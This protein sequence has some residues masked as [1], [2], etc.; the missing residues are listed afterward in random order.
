MPLREGKKVLS[1]PD[2][3]KGG[4]CIHPEVFVEFGAGWGTNPATEQ[5]GAEK[6]W[7]LTCRTLCGGIISEIASLF[8]QPKV[9][10][11]M[12]TPA[13]LAI[14]HSVTR[15]QG[16]GGHNLRKVQFFNVLD[17]GDLR[18]NQPRPAQLS[19]ASVWS[20][21]EWA[22][23]FCCDN[24]HTLGGCRQQTPILLRF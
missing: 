20:A 17:S 4:Y 5:T 21:F 14:T 7:P 16:R 22:F 15:P 6:W 3:A 18:L 10:N 19:P 12:W 24:S 23:S 11:S 13:T 1:F 9:S 2:W 8:E